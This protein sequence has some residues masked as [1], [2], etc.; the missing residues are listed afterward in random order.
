MAIGCCYNDMVFN[1]F[2][3]TRTTYIRSHYDLQNINEM[4]ALVIFC[5]WL[6]AA[7][8]LISFLFAKH[9]QLSKKC[10]WW[11]QILVLYN[12]HVVLLQ[13]CKIYTWNIDPCFPYVWLSV[14]Q[15]K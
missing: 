11:F 5:I 6:Q 2:I 14:P 9:I 1:I 3:K 7:R 13:I 10:S 15:L 8:S 4:W 12:I